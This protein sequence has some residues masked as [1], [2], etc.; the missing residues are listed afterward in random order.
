MIWRLKR[1]SPQTVAGSLRLIEKL[2]RA[3][4]VLIARRRQ[5]TH[6]KAVALTVNQQAQ[7]AISRCLMELQPVKTPA[8]CSLGTDTSN[9]GSRTMTASRPRASVRLDSIAHPALLFLFRVRL[10]LLMS[11]SSTTL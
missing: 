1:V 2:S 8:L 7:L 9:Q 5:R 11:R 3:N 4:S 10:F 6:L